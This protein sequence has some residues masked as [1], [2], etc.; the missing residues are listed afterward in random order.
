[1]RAVGVALCR[2]LDQQPL[3][4]CWL[5]PSYRRHVPDEPAAGNREVSGV[6][7][8]V[9]MPCNLLPPSVASS[10]PGSWL[11]R[12]VVV[13]CR[14]A[15]A[16]RAGRRPDLGAGGRRSLRRAAR[17]VV[18]AGSR[19][20]SSTSSLIPRTQFA[21]SHRPGPSALHASGTPSAA[22]WRGRRGDL[23]L[24][25]KNRMS[26]RRARRADPPQPARPGPIFR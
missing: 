2:P 15:T 11:R 8:P 22:A 7:L 10:E 5:A 17:T 14:G 6:L 13:A 12:A 19:P 25:L 21:S 20:V 24:G 23:G 16:C 3:L 9:M 18:V 1:M 4:C 26:S